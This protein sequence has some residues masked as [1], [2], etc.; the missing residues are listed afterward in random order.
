ML[1]MLFGKAPYF[2]TPK[3]YPIWLTNAE[4]WGLDAFLELDYNGSIS[5]TDMAKWA[6][7]K[8]KN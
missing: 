3:D 4:T 5:S 7:Y 8:E 6:D 1:A 2:S